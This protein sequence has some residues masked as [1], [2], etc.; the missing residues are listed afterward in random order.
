[1]T[2]NKNTSNIDQVCYEV[3]ESESAEQLS[4]VQQLESSDGESNELLEAP[5]VDLSEQK[6]ALQELNS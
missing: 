6:E 3:D 2:K 4:H 1:M 5:A